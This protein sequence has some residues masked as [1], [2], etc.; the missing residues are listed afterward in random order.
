MHRAQQ[1]PIEPYRGKG[2]YECGASMKD[3]VGRVKVQECVGEC[4][5]MALVTPTQRD[6]TRCCTAA[7]VGRPEVTLVRGRGVRW[8]GR[9]GG[10]RGGM[11]LD[12]PSG[13]S[14][15]VLAAPI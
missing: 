11:P 7:S 13:L 9:L 12:G 15:N 6:R 3:S 5:S 10:G 8:R 14:V 1:S 2:V 4:T